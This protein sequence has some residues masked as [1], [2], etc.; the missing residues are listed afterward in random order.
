MNEEGEKGIAE[1]GQ[2]KEGEMPTNKGE[3]QAKYKMGC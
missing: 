1:T 2:G 3:A